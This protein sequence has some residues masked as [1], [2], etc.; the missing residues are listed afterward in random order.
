M[1]ERKIPAPGINPETE[2]FWAAARE[3]R[4]LV[5]GCAACG[6]N[7]WY[8]RAICPFCFS[9]RTEWRPASGRGVIYSVSV[10]KRAPEPYAIAYVTLEEGP[11][12]MTNIVDCDLDALRIGQ[13][14]RLVFKPTEGGGPPFPMFTPA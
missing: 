12:M 2:P 10:M 9:D 8:P 14:V 1:A 13:P 11:T 7:H 5:K 3:G 4:F 6:K